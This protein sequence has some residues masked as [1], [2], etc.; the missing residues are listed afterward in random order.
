M[1]R[2]H[3]FLDLAA[4]FKSGESSPSREVDACLKR[5]DEREPALKA[6]V[7]V[8]RDAAKAAAAASDARWK[9]GTPLS[10]ID[11]MIVGIKDIIETADLPTGQGSP[12]WVGFETR[13]DAASVQ[14]LREAGAIVIG[15]TTTTEYA[16]AHTNAPTTNPHDPTRTPGGSS[17][18]SAAAVGSGV[19][20]AGLGTQVIGSILR[21]ASFCGAVG[22]KPSIGAVNRGGSYDYLSQSAQGVIA[23]TPTDA[24]IVLAAIVRK[25]GGDPGFLGLHGPETPPAAKA[26]KKL[27]VLRTAHW[28]KASV[29]AREAFAAAEKRLAALGVTLADAKAEPKI[30]A[31][32]QAIAQCNPE[33]LS[34]NGWESLW[35]LGTYEARDA[36]KISAMALGRLKD[37]RMMT[38]DD[39]RVLLEHRVAARA[40][41]ED[42]LKTHDGFVMLGALG[43]APV[44]LN[45]TGDSTMNV[46]A[47][48]LG[49]PA[50][51]L[52]LLADE[53][54]P[55]G[56]QLIGG[57][58]RDAHLMAIAAWVWENYGEG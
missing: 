17:S 48:Y 8:G 4:A 34:I 51:T 37:A 38:V 57:M 58:D 49:G 19:I 14:G 1:S 47:S 2:P 55:L 41:S 25:V 40:I 33:S 32:E 3:S 54:M 5:I 27:A 53:G 6:F 18:G 26:P 39:Y 13:R 46:P 43:A 9:A 16:A 35:P 50:I 31:L 36:S 29:G 7:H 22:F 12:L 42:I 52:P 45:Y 30:A 44:G 20:P 28:Q 15:K 10:A 21:P 11:G 24:W 56:L 23:Q